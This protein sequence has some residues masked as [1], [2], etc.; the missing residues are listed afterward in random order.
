MEPRGSERRRLSREIDAFR[1]RGAASQRDTGTCSA[2]S[3]RGVSRSLR[4]RRSTA[5]SRAAFGDLSGAAHSIHHPHLLDRQA[6]ARAALA[7]KAP[8][9]IFRDR[10]LLKP[11]GPNFVSGMRKT[12][13]VGSGSGNRDFFPMPPAHAPS[14]TGWPPHGSRRRS[15]GRHSGCGGRRSSPRSRARPQPAWSAGRARAGRQPLPRARLA[16]PASRL[17][18]PR[19]CSERARPSSPAD[20]RDRRP[21]LV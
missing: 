11:D 18:A 17:A 12:R 16:P 10:F 4:R 7:T 21:R 5:V 2:A 1:I 3:A 20:I 8:P 14:Q 6:Q 13:G 15:F 19:P 9:A